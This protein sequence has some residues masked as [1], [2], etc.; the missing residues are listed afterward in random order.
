MTA[1]TLRLGAGCSAGAIERGRSVETSMGF[2]PLEGL[3]M[4]TRSGD[5]DPVVVFE[6]LRRGESPEAVE[7]MLTRESGM[8]GLSGQADMRALLA[9]EESGDERAHVA[10]S[11]FVRRIV[12]TTGAY[13]TLLGGE[14]A[15][16]FG[17]GIGARSPEIRRRVAEGLA[18]WGI[19]LDPA[20]N[21][22][23]GLGPL[24]S[25]GS[26]PVYAFETDEER[27][28]ARIVSDL[29]GGG[30]VER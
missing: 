15:L 3:A 7:H 21:A 16:V 18:A 4:A 2:S 25:P 14:G 26:R 10:V 27:R 8:L 28:I 30:G 11:L 12:M 1:V 23:G 19:S 29:L 13:L 17:G 5:V 9:A 24:G 22:S 6:L 20:R